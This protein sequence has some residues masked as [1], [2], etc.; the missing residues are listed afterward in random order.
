[1]QFTLFYTAKCLYIILFIFLISLLLALKFNVSLQKCFRFWELHPR[2][3]AGGWPLEPTG[4]FPSPRHHKLGVPLSK[5]LCHAWTVVMVWLMLQVACIYVWW[6]CIV[7]KCLNSSSWFLVRAL[8]QNQLLC[9]RWGSGSMHE[10][11]DLPWR[12]DVG[13]R[14]LHCC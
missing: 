13:H 10:K 9:V 3:P 2:F 11:A 14:Q 1:M 4:R 12:W 6:W 7:V 5:M 8:P